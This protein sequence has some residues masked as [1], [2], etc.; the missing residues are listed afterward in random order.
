MDILKKISAIFYRVGLA[1]IIATGTLLLTITTFY[2][3]FWRVSYVLNA[4]IIAL[5]PNY[6][7]SELATDIIFTNSGN[8]QCAI[9]KSYLLTRQY[10]ND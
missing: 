6:N 9:V 8:R 4:T 5:K 1:N 3:Q 10:A 7:G 2:Y